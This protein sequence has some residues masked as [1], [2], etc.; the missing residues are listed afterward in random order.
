MGCVAED[1]NEV[2]V[3]SALDLEFARPILEEFERSSGIRVRAKYDVEST[4]TVG[5]TNAL[6]AE[7]ARPR[8][9]VFW[10]NEILNTLRLQRRNLLSPYD[11][12][13]KNRFP[14]DYRAA[15]M[16]WYGF[17]A[18]AR[19]L[20]VNRELLPDRSEWPSSVLDLADR[21]W[22]HKVGLAKPLFGTTATHATILFERWGTDQATEFFREVS[23]NARVLSGNKQVA[24]AVSRGQIAWGLT[25]TD[26]AIIEVEQGLPVAI[27]YPDQAD[28]AMGTLFIPNTVARIRSGPNPNGAGQLIDYLLSAGTEN[29]LAKSRSAQIPLGR[30]AATQDRVRTPSQIRAMQVD[31]EAAAA[32]WPKAAPILRHEFMWTSKSESR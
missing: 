12:P 6:I 3:Y 10:N 23:K 32:M 15:D 16:T 28:G 4:K 29:R 2:V 11:S 18:R 13:E 8:C 21:H 27:V 14:K 5:L 22:Q 30:G 26:D 31:F 25:D 24:R 1:H 20:L 7:S 9:D 19:V 17:A